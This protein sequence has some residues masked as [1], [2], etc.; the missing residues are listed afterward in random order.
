MRKAETVLITVLMLALCSIMAS[1]CCGPY[2]ER[3]A[4]NGDGT[5][6]VFLVCE[7]CGI[8]GYFSGKEDCDGEG[9]DI[10]V[11]CGGAVEICRHSRTHEQ[12]LYTQ[13]GVMV[14]D[15]PRHYHT[16]DHKII[17][18]DC[19]YSKIRKDPL[20]LCQDADEDLVCDICACQLHYEHRFRVTTSYAPSTPGCHVLSYACPSCEFSA[21][22]TQRCVVENDICTLC[23]A[24]AAPKDDFVCGFNMTIGNE[25]KLNVL[26]QTEALPQG[27]YTAVFHHAGKEAVKAELEPY[28]DTYMF[29]SCP[30]AAKEMTDPIRV[31]I[32]DKDGI[33]LLELN[34]TSVKAYAMTLLRHDETSAVLSRVVVDLLNYGAEAQKYFRYETDRLANAELTAEEAAFATQTVACENLLQADE[35]YLGTTLSLEDRILLNMFFR[36]KDAVSAEYVYIN[37]QGQP[38]SG[39]C[40]VTQRKTFC[41]VTVDAQVFADAKCPVKIIVF[42]ENGQDTAWCEDSVESYLARNEGRDYGDL[43]RAIMKVASSA[44]RHFGG[45]SWGEE[46]SVFASQSVDAVEL[47]TGMIFPGETCRIG[48]PLDGYAVFETAPESYP[49]IRTG[50]L[51]LVGKAKDGKNVYLCTGKTEDTYG[52]DYVAITC[53]EYDGDLTENRPSREACDAKRTYWMSEYGN[54]HQIYTLDSMF[55]G[56]DDPYVSCEAAAVVG[57]YWLA[58]DGA[59]VAAFGDF[60]EC[61]FEDHNLGPIA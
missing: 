53:S 60:I 27:T 19:G 24:A 31:E 32:Y 9:E 7:E 3:Y 17:C 8:D 61:T 10:C 51:R 12:I 29:A 52:E 58:P 6:D 2:W 39:P 45:I 46:Q 41:K 1:A 13:Y 25:L 50:Y 54:V 35:K 55:T 23:G 56:A 26:L 43:C 18:N 28:N 21:E 5:H 16:T 36:V 48:G 20:A 11:Y 37:Y 59:F 57:Q 14:S 47:D 42:D 4:A 34:E 30:V 49:V 44:Y 22:V 33:R 38:V 40:T 15:S